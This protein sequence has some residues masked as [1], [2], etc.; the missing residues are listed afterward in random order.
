M[1][2]KI[3]RG[4]IVDFALAYLENVVDRESGE[5]IS[6]FPPDLTDLWDDQKFRI[7]S[8]VVPLLVEIK[9]PPTRSRPIKNELRVDICRLER[10]RYLTVDCQFSCVVDVT[11]TNGIGRELLK[12]TIPSKAFIQLYIRRKRGSSTAFLLTASNP[13]SAVFFQISTLFPPPPY[14]FWPLATYGNYAVLCVV[15]TCLRER[16]S[17]WTEWRQKMPLRVG[18]ALE[19]GVQNGEGARRREIGME[20]GGRSRG[21]VNGAANYGVQNID[22]SLNL[23]SNNIQGP[24]TFVF[25]ARCGAN[26]PEIAQ[27]PRG[28]QFATMLQ[29]SGYE[30][31]K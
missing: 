17:V 14:P 5:K 24:T 28:D 20:A 8:L 30:Q 10:E 6:S 29:I 23:K 15:A 2:D 26:L 27:N 18:A 19:S 12:A 21:K 7:I 22:S 13:S 3:A 25:A 1:P 31:R 4:V 9:K 11:N 16:S